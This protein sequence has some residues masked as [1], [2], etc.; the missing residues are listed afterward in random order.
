M[1]PYLL[2]AHVYPCVTG[3]HVVLMD[4]ERDKY[5]AVAPA[6][7]LA[8]WVRGWPVSAA[9]GDCADPDSHADPDPL[10]SQMLAQGML[11]SDPQLGKPAQPLTAVAARGSL[12]QFDLDAR[13]QS[14]A[15]DLP[16]LAVGHAR[17]RLSL[18]V[19]PIQSLVESVRERKARGAG[20]AAPADERLLRARVRAFTRLRPLFYTVRGAC[21]LDS[22]TLLN[23]LA[24]EGIHP[25]WVFGVKTEPFDAHC[26]VQQGEMLLNDVP[27]RVRQYSPLLIV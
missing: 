8:P 23:F 27:D 1:Q 4:L 26:W 25:D 18:A 17:A 6:H 2:A 11:V 5:I 24:P 14:F 10:V 9:A 19:R 22:L 3:Q 15:A 13:R 20:K 16:R 21:L 7:R 12:V